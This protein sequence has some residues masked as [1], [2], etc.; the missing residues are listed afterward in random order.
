MEKLP[1]ALSY[2]DVLL[3]PNSSVIESRKEV[4]LTTRLTDRLTLKIPLVATKMDSVT[5]VEMAV[6]MGKLGGMAIIPRF[7]SPEIQATKVAAVKKE[8]V[9]I[10]AAVGIKDGYLERAEM[11]VKA[12]ATVLNIDVAHG[13]MERNMVVTRKLKRIFGRSVV[14]ISGIAATAKCAEDLY[15]AGADCILVGVG[16]G[17]ICTTRVQTGCGVPGL[18]SLLWVSRVARKYGKTFLPDA[19]IR[20]SG[21]IVK[22]LAAGA[23]AICAGSLFAGTDEAPGEVVV[24][25]GETYKT[26]NGSASVVEKKRQIAKYDK[27]K[28]GHYVEQVEGVASL[29]KAKGPVEGVVNSLL[30]GVRSGMSYCGARSIEELWLRA[31]FIRITGAGRVENGAHDVRVSESG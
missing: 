30:A 24:I 11:L 28:E 14:I 22:A 17:S 1:L 3:I 25:D 20:S 6:K 4:D 16:A 7:D 23:S 9:V 29:V 26:Y 5:G 13:H 2:D 12:G 18:T 10:A 27:D 15:R 8:K 19:G 21:D 31:R